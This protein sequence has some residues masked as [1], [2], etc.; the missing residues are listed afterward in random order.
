MSFMSWFY[1]SFY[2]FKVIAYSRFRPIT[3]TL[4]HILFLVF[5]ASLPYLIIMNVTIYNTVHQLKETIHIGLPTFS[6]EN[7]QLTLENDETYIELYNDQL[8]SLILDP[9]EQLTEHDY[10]GEHVIIFSQHTIEMYSAN[11][12]YSL[13][14]SLLGLNNVTNSD[15]IERVDQLSNFL[16]LLLTI[17]TILL[18]VILAGTA[19]LGVTII[20]LFALLLRQNRKL[21]YRHMWSVSAHAMTLP[22]VAFFWIDALL[23]D[24]HYIWFLL[25]SIT[26]I[27]FSIRTIPLPRS[28]ESINQNQ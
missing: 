7:G 5:V 26:M 3:N 17:V 1:K 10:H 25:F 27:I 13:S 4:G 28:K 24:L 11:E 9:H 14:Y 6:I 12:S 8:G 19:Y 2:Q 23:L 15:V 20:A 21:E 16:P 18:Y 22:T